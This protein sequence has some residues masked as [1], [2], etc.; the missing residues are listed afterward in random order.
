MPN[1][2]DFCEADNDFDPLTDCGD[3]WLCSQCLETIQIELDY[4]E[5]KLT[6]FEPVGE[7]E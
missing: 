7:E 5:G 2:C 3:Y 1:D 4:L 6:H